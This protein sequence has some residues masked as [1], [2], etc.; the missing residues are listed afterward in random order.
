MICLIPDDCP[1]SGQPYYEIISVTFSYI[2][3]TEFGFSLSTCPA[4]KKGPPFSDAMIRI[5]IPHK[6]MRILAPGIFIK[7]LHGSGLD[8]A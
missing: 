6:E 2:L 4:R 5:V 1:F 8:L 7:L 3:K